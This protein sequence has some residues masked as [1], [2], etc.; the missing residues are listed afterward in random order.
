VSVR[1][2]GEMVQRGFALDDHV[3]FMQSAL[4]V[5]RHRCAITGRIFPP[6]ETAVHPDLTVFLFQHMEH[7]GALSLGNSL[8]VDIGAAGL[9]GKGVL[10]IDDDYRS[11]VARPDLFDPGASSPASDERPLFLP[12][13]PI[14]WPTR[15]A[16][17]YHRSMFRIQ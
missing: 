6:S 7:G 10:M 8:V 5:Y 12:D 3:G 11:F 16:L 4:A 2:F 17:A 15:N 14:Y 1:G 13:D 9:L